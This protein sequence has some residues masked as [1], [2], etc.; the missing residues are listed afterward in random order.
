MRLVETYH[1][2]NGYFN[3]YSLIFYI[4]L[5]A[6]GMIAF[7]GHNDSNLKENKL[8]Q[9]KTPIR[10]FEDG[11]FENNEIT[12]E[13]PGKGTASFLVDSYAVK[14]I[15]SFE[16]RM[17]NGLKL[18]FTFNDVSLIDLDES[19]GFVK[20]ASHEI[21]EKLNFLKFDEYRNSS[22]KLW[23]SFHGFQN[24]CFIK[25]GYGE[26]FE[27][28]VVFRFESK[29]SKGIQLLREIYSIQIDKLLVISDL[30]K[31]NEGLVLDMP[32]TINSLNRISIENPNDNYFLMNPIRLPSEIYELQS[33][34]SQFTINNDDLEAIRFDYHEITNGFLNNISLTKKDSP[35]LV[36][37]LQSEKYIILIEIYP[38]AYTSPIIF[39]SNEY[40]GVYKVLSGKFSFKWF[41]SISGEKCLQK[42]D[43][44]WWVSNRIFQTVQIK[45]TNE[46]EIAV[47]LKV[48]YAPKNSFISNETLI[49][50][51]DC[52]FF[53]MSNQV[54]NNYIRSK[55]PSYNQ[56]LMIE[57]GK[58]YSSITNDIKFDSFGQG[59]FSF[60][61]KSYNFKN[62]NEYFSIRLG[63]IYLNFS[64]ND[65]R[66]DLDQSHGF[67]KNLGKKKVNY[68][69]FDTNKNTLWVS[70]SGFESYFIKI[71]YGYEA[72]INV[73]CTFET[74]ETKGINL[75]Q[76]IKAI[77]VED[78]IKIKV[79]KIEN[80]PFLFE[81][82]LMISDL[83]G[84]KNLFIE[85]SKS[86]TSHDLSNKMNHLYNLISHFHLSLE[87]IEA[88]NFSLDNQNCFLHEQ[89]K[90]KQEQKISFQLETNEIIKSEFQILMEIYPKKVSDKIRKNKDALGIYR[91][92]SGAF[93]FSWYNSISNNSIDQIDSAIILRDDIIRL[94][95]ES[96]EINKLDNIQSELA[97]LILKG[98]VGSRNINSK[99]SYVKF[100]E[101]LN[102]V[103]LEYEKKS[104]NGSYP[105]ESCKLI[106][107]D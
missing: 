48:I 97:S 29:K 8:I 103:E 46:D 67:Q 81:P 79:L 33:I 37:F 1:I 68:L 25:V 24:P 4:F 16:L 61:I 89:M 92:L 66:I 10:N 60:K 21:L 27:N 64:Y 62:N 77:S 87:Q 105:I 72:E 58:N 69:N 36:K 39:H 28:N 73:L 86:I 53:E 30:V 98:Y 99:K 13:F 35:I 26:L 88:I 9:S 43:I 101:F 90:K 76:E 38:K 94:L 34:A 18:M 23:I 78:V 41:N 102:K 70:F 83:K 47:L 45:N 44:T 49:L 12:F 22:I 7:H 32:I 95:P 17:N 5:I 96:H 75:L 84:N 14:N 51:F 63:K 65:V 20:K 52:D 15:K 40:F 2:I 85:R 55:K 100:E 3:K 91:V 59:F 42:D 82:P 93:N 104:C 19:H 107:F 11:M 106:F 50:N 80:T 6:V 71:G 74:N 31:E 56:K 57:Q 54:R